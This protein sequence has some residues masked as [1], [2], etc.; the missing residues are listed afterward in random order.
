L[1]FTD[2]YELGTT[3]EWIR[4]CDETKPE[5]KGEK[6]LIDNLFS[7]QACLG[8]AE[9]EDEDLWEN[10]SEWIERLN[11]SYKKGQKISKEDAN[12][13]SRDSEGWLST[14]YKE[15][16]GRPCLE[17]QKGALNQK[18]LIVTSEGKASDIFDKKVWNALPRIAQKDFSEAAKCLLVGASTAAAMVSLRG[19]EAVVRNF[20]QNKTG[21]SSGKSD[22][23]KILD[24]LA[25]LPQINRKLL[26]YMDYIRSEKRNI[27]QHPTRVFS[28]R[29]AERIFME[30]INA[31]HDIYPEMS[32]PTEPEA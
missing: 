13:L 3:I 32:Q 31:S 1:D 24:E 5:V 11:K 27:A 12:E 9:I 14:V 26:E 10:I 23:A 22:L 2:A 8:L 25:V 21:K 30:I 15:I 7:L 6:W 18:A 16:C 29:E 20:Y 28:Q 19:I 4:N 17:F